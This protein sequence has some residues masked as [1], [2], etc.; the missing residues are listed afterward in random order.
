MLCPK[1]QGK[2]DQGTTEP[3]SILK[4]YG[5]V[6]W[7]IACECCDARIWCTAIVHSV[8]AL[9]HL[10][11][12]DVLAFQ[13]PYPGKKRVHTTTVAPLPSW[14]VARP[15][16][17]GFF[18]GYFIFFSARGGGRG[19]PRCRLRIAQSGYERVQK[20]FCAWGP[21]ARCTG[22]R[23]GCIGATQG[24]TGVKIS[25]ETFLQLAKTPFAPSPIHFG[26]F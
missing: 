26:L 15:Q 25:W 4:Q 19:S 21:K 3:D 9:Q 1:K 18:S 11:A 7:K 17:G 8:Q 24:C 20:V 13:E 14:S 2:E 12:R 5:R 10:D 22:A 23:E 16:L 6:L